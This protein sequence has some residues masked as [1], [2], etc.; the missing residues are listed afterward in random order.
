LVILHHAVEFAMTKKK[1]LICPLNWGIGH[2]SRC[3]PLIQELLDLEQEIIIAADKA[4]LALLQSAFPTI[5]TVRFPGF[6]PHYSSSNS[7]VLKTAMSIPRLVKSAVD[8][9]N[10][11]EQLVRV[12]GLD[13]VISDNRYGAYSRKVPSVFITHQLHIHLPL[14][15]I[16][17]RPLV[18]KLNKKYIRNYGSCWVPDFEDE[19]NLS[20]ALSHPPLKGLNVK[21]IGPLSRF[22]LEPIEEKEFSYDLLVMLSGPEPQRTLLEMKL[23]RE[24]N[25]LPLNVCILRGKP[26]Y[27]RKLRQTERLHLH[28]HAN[29]EQI[30][31]LMQ[32]SRLI[33][34]RPGYST[35]MDLIAMQK[36][37][38]LVPTPGQTEQEYLARRMKTK[39][40]FNWGKQDQFDVMY[41]INDTSNY[42]PSQQTAS[43]ISLK[44]HLSS[45]LQEF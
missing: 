5:E 6:E 2:A 12:K 42:H 37:A 4:P 7:Q 14:T 19:P 16:G 11:V 29:D 34:S 17:L 21:Y 15:L 18:N 45:W 8:D 24:I 27:H 41:A 39:Q 28:N 20:G 25:G 40:W 33:I 1:I 9:N 13:A 43:R 44:E 22:S 36:K 32:S 30:R 38:F 31:Q 35:I 3:V 10:F 26:D 23:I